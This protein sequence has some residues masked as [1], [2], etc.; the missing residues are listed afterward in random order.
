MMDKLPAV[1]R[2]GLIVHELPEE[3]LIY[4][5]DRDK[6]HCLNATAAFI[7]K[8]CNGKTT[9]PALQAGLKKEFGFANETMI[10]LALDQMEKFDLLQT[11]VRRSAAM[12]GIS[13]RTVIRS[14]GVAAI[15]SVPLITT[16]IA[17]TVHALVSCQEPGHS[18]GNQAQCCS[19]NCNAGVCG[20]PL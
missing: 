8:H 10:W 3:V 2:E 6:A 18:C 4:D 11:P 1:R 15:A 14:M 9:V 20:P 13:R 7:W 19:Q 5:V 17:P 16:I 12:K